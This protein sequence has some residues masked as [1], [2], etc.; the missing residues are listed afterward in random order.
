MRR[1]TANRLGIVGIVAVVLFVYI[2]TRDTIHVSGDLSREDQREL[3]AGIQEWS[4]PKLFRYI[5]LERTEYGAVARVRE[6][7]G[8]WSETWFAKDS[9]HWQ[10][11]NWLLLGEDKRAV[12]DK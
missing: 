6:P 4:A 8:H 3:I 11:I 1:S 10:K 2:R 9:G 5:Q 12:Q 7:G